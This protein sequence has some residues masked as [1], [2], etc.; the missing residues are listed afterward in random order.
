MAISTTSNTTTTSS[1]EIKYEKPEDRATLSRDDFMKLFVTQLQYQD[2]SSPMDSAEM[3]SQMAQF[4]MVDLMQKNNEAMEKLV[5]ND[6]TRT[7]LDAVSFIGKDVEYKGS[8]VK[9][10]DTGVNPFKLELDKD[11]TS[12]KVTIKDANNQI[13]RQL[14]LGDVPAGYKRIDWDGKD[15]LGNTLPAGK[16]NISV[17]ASNN[18]GEQVKTSIWTKGAVLG[19]NLQGKDT[20]KLVV[21]DGTEVA[22]SELNAVS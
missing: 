14:D 16:Y 19:V 4:N 11:A 6:I 12:V 1:S 7:R 18:D 13:V 2:P 10:T 8:S 21:E 22:I 3:S 20:I 17:A 5:A 9:I 15:E